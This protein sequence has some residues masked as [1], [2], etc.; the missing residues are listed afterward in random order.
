M[1]KESFTGKR[2][3]TDPHM[4]T[5][6][7]R[8]LAADS[9]SPV[10]FVGE[11]G[12]ASRSVGTYVDIPVSIRSGRTAV[13]KPAFDREG[14]EL[15]EH[16]T[17]DVDFG[18][19]RDVEEH[20]YPQIARLF[21]E[22]LGA[23][24]VLVFDHTVRVAAETEGVRK[25]VRHVHNDYTAASTAQRVSDLTGSRSSS[26]MERRF[27]QVNLW[28]P[29]NIPALNSPLAILDAQ[30]LELEHLVKAAV[31]YSERRGEVYEV[32]HNNSHRWFFF[33]S[34]M[35]SEALIFRGYDSSETVS[36]PFT[37]HTAFDVPNSPADAPPRKSIELRA[38]AF[39]N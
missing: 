14:F 3:M 13:P 28:R 18:S 7:L 19:D 37:P 17:T 4:I 35:P 31:V 12:K 27:A 39:F 20:Y 38:M 1:R 9:D 26:L 24:E 23:A 34:M 16:K 22:R 8:Y 15:V 33:P 36:H 11:P 30:S 29:I 6:P 32:V 10:F 2:P 21:Q 25:P 5:A